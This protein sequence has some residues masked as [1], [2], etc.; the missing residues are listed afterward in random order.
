[1]PY[2]S[3]NIISDFGGRPAPQYFNPITDQYEPSTGNNGA[4]NVRDNLVLRD[5]WEG[6]VNVTK[7]FASSMSY[8]EVINNGT[9]DVTF[10]IGTITIRVAPGY[11]FGSSFDP[12]TSVTIVTTSAYQ[13]IVKS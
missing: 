9:T 3:K 4:L 12:F 13:A 7:T 1:M 2:G 11:G 6:N 8:L 10:T 5:S